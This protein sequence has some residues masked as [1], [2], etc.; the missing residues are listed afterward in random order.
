M[1]IPVKDKSWR[2]GLIK[3]N[4]SQAVIT[5]DYF[6]GY[7]EEYLVENGYDVDIF[8]NSFGE[9]LCYYLYALHSHF[10]QLLNKCICF[11]KCRTG[12]YYSHYYLSFHDYVP[13]NLTMRLERVQ[14]AMM[15]NGLDQFYFAFATFKGHIISR[16]HL[17]A[18]EVEDALKILG[19]EQ[20]SL[21]FIKTLVF[22]YFQYKFYLLIVN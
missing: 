17:E 12:L 5:T 11:W 18:E 16:H 13:K 10:F 21:F 2:L 8:P 6:V 7:L 4:F 20:M 15:E 3:E 9:F 19:L 1:E 14:R 22:N